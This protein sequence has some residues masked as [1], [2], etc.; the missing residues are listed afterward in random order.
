MIRSIEYDGLVNEID[1]IKI[2]YYRGDLEDVSLSY[3]YT[4]HKSQG[5][6]I[7]VVLVISPRSHIY[8]SNGNLLYTSV[9]RASDYVFHFGLPDTIN[10]AM[11]KKEN[12]NR[13]TFTQELLINLYKERVKK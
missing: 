7:K 10:M 6:T 4:I 12:Y 2:K 3:A 8:M 11:R 13:N 9:T 1:G 5:S